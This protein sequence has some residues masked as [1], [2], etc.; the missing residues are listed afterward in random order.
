MVSGEMVAAEDALAMGL[1]DRI[2]G[3]SESL[4]DAVEDFLTPMRKQAPQVMRVFK[5]LADA[6]R[7][8]DSRATMHDIE[9]E[10]FVGTWVHD[11]HWAAAEKV[12]PSRD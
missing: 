2:A 10:R 8:G 1:I 9:T 7:R 12:L 6:Y 5:A 4:S 3:D 11:D